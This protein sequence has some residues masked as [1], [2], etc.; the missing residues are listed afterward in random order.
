MKN[1]ATNFLKNKI[2]FLAIFA[3]TA[4][5]ITSCETDELTEYKEYADTDYV[6][7]K[8]QPLNIPIHKDANVTY[9]KGSICNS[10]LNLCLTTNI[11]L[12]NNSVSALQYLII[13]P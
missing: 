6:L 4:M 9:L 10:S 3:F 7:G 13:S 5:L 12:L 11:D 1:Q 2:K 8:K